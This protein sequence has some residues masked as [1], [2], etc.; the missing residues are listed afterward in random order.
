VL[1]AEVTLEVKQEESWAKSTGHGTEVWQR[2]QTQGLEKKG[3]R[4]LRQAGKPW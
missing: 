2:R 4:E 1:P 3:D